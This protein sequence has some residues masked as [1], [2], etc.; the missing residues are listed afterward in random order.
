MR[1]AYRFYFR[2]VLPRL[3]GL[4]S[5]DGSAY[6]YLPA[7][8][9]KFPTPEAFAALMREAG[10]GDVSWRLL[11]GGHRVPAPRGEA[12]MNRLGPALQR[13]AEWLRPHRDAVLAD[14]VRAVADVRGIAEADARAGLRAR[15][16]RPARPPLRRRR[17][18][19]ARGGGA[20]GRARGP[21][22]REPARRRPGPPRAGPLPRL[23]AR[24][25]LPRPRRARRERWWP[26]TS[27]GTAGS[28]PSSSR[29]RTSPRA[30]WSR[31]RSR[32]R[33]RRSARAR[34]SGRTRRCAGRRRRAGTGRSRSGCS[35]RW[36]TGSRPSASPRS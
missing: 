4:V 6:A 21:P 16:R 20:A 27:S 34:C 10:F 24:L 36:P 26:S 35:R 9:A 1:Q 31:P 13:A 30:G 11:T 14:W 33:G 15:P 12:A 28:R 25:G 23:R 19:R 29:R 3:G 22:R 7:S 17:R 8:V 18:G 5:G 2:S 32:R